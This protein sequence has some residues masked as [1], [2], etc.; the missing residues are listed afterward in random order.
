MAEKYTSEE[1]V[2]KL[3]EP[4]W[5][6]V[7]HGKEG[8]LREAAEAAHAGRAGGKP[9]GRLQ[10]IATRIEVEL[11]ELEELWHHLGLPV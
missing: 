6:A 4:G 3:N 2:R 11:I 7:D 5:R 9:P 1:L 10:E 8:T